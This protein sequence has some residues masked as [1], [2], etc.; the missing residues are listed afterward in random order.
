MF[1]NQ[2]SFESADR[3]GTL[4]PELRGN[5]AERFGMPLLLAVFAFS[6]ISALATNV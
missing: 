6:W 5:F 2:S 3:A 4:A 1:L